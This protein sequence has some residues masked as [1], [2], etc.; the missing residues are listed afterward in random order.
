MI[1]WEGGFIFFINYNKLIIS[2]GSVGG[3]VI[4][5]SASR[6]G[7]TISRRPPRQSWQGPQCL[8][9]LYQLLIAPFE[10]VLPT[11]CSSKNSG[12]KFLYFITPLFV[13]CFK[14]LKSFI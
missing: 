7:S 5:G 12:R 9:A 8:F 3:S 1:Y 2:L 11:S 6:P 14:V 4:S 13:Y 10:D